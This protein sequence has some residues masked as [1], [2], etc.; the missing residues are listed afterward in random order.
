MDGVSEGCSDAH[1][2]LLFLTAPLLSVRGRVTGQTELFF[3]FI[4]LSVCVL[5][6]FFLL[7]AASTY[8]ITNDIF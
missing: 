2:E 8:S 5:S 3:S 7:L 1:R 4:L 6:S